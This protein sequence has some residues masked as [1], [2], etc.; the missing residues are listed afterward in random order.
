MNVLTNGQNYDSNRCML[1]MGEF[2]STK[3][4]MLC[5][6]Q[7]WLVISFGV[8]QAMLFKHSIQYGNSVCPSI[9]LSDTYEPCQNGLMSSDFFYHQVTPSSQ[10]S[11]NKRHGEIMT[12]PPPG[13]LHTDHAWDIHRFWSL[14]DC[15]L[16]IVKDKRH[17]KRNS[18]RTHIWSIALYFTTDKD[19]STVEEYFSYWKPLW[20]QYLVIYS[21]YY[22]KLHLKNAPIVAGHLRGMEK[23]ITIGIKTSSV[24]FGPFGSWIMKVCRNSVYP[25]TSSRLLSQKGRKRALTE[26]IL[27]TSHIAYE[28]N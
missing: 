27:N 26:C 18:N 21:I 7:S 2:L 3:F 23:V 20:D 28:T 24:P 19:L 8:H 17:S 5:G 25:V 13:I 4:L 1:K 11:L 10:F 16:Q 12:E 14:A 22:Y 9:C 6:K 15:V